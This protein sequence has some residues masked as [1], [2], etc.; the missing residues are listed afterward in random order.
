MN[1]IASSL[2]HA[3]AQLKE[4][5]GAE[6]VISLW[7][8]EAENAPRRSPDEDAYN[9]ENPILASVKDGWL[10]GY[11]G[12]PWPGPWPKQSG[13]LFVSDPE[14]WQAGIAWE[15]QGPEITAIAGPSKT[16]WGTYQ[17]LFPIPVMSE[18]DLIRNFHAVLPLL[19]AERMKVEQ[20]ISR[21]NS[22]A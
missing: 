16:R 20:G 7:N 9:Q 19:K 22:D 14:G 10:I 8:E 18:H 11:I 4:S 12:M 3:E 21:A 5:Y 17:V 2:E 13:D 15:S 1:V 6:A